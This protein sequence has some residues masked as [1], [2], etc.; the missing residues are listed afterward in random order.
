MI[1]SEYLEMPGLRLTRGQA[2]RLW[3]FDAV[4]C[5]TLLERLVLTGFLCRTPKGYIRAPSLDHS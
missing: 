3:G 2:Q 5:E 4:T 1:R